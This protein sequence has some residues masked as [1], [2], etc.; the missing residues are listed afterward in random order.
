M[1]LKITTNGGY[2]DVGLFYIT[3][4]EK[5]EIE[6]KDEHDWDEWVAAR[7]DL[8]HMAVWSES[9]SFPVY[10]LDDKFEVVADGEWQTLPIEQVKLITENQDIKGFING[11][12]AEY[13]LV[14]W[15]FA[16]GGN[17]Y[18]LPDGDWFVEYQP[19]DVVLYGNKIPGKLLGQD[20]IY[21][22]DGFEYQDKPFDNEGPETGG[23]DI[24]YN[25]INTKEI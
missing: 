6:S 5:K 23:C 16:K 8:H 14:I 21:Y 1:E 12:E 11:E 3:D 18:I 15:C 9:M 24:Y 4:D 22:I 25:I 7:P 17:T 2:I 13:V 20:D 19:S 10:N